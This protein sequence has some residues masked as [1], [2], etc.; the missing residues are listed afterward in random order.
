MP[1]LFLSQCSLRMEKVPTL[2]L[3]QCALRM[4]KVP[5]FP[6]SQ[7]ALRMEEVSSLSLSQCAFAT[8]HMLAFITLIDF[9][10]LPLENED[11]DKPEINSLSPHI[12]PLVWQN[13]LF[14]LSIPILLLDK[15]LVS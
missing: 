5:S 6:F 14:L 7:C 2:F 13:T 8:W 11:P 10:S 12:P 3:S 15:K 1:S 9:L 4:E